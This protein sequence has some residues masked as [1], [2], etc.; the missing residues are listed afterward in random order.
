[1]TS[2][3]F[4]GLKQKICFKFTISN[5]MFYVLRLGHT[6][7]YYTSEAEI[8]NHDHTLLNGGTLI[9]CL[10]HKLCSFQ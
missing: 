4:C 7:K 5:V 3:T 1:M 2:K 10:E 6:D 9:F 8:V